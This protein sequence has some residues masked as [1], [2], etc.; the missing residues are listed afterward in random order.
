MCNEGGCRLWSGLPDRSIPGPVLAE[1]G[2]DGVPILHGEGFWTDNHHG[3]FNVLVG[4]EK[5]CITEAVAEVEMLPTPALLRVWTWGLIWI[6]LI[7]DN[8]L[9]L[10]FLN[11]K[12]E[13][14]LANTLPSEFFCHGE[15]PEP[16]DL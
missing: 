16:V 2:G 10:V 13:N 8:G 15:V 11:Q 12:C 3:H 5:V 6:F 4:L 7:K 9:A 14:L 1:F